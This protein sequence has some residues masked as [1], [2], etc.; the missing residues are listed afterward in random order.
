MPNQAIIFPG[1]GSQTVGMGKYFYEN[2]GA[3]KSIFNKA[4]TLGCYSFFKKYKVYQTNSI[5][6]SIFKNYI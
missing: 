1:Q 3:V 5:T 6:D 2:F 4:Q